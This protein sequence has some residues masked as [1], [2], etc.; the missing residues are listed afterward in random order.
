MFK[1]ILVFG[2]LIII[3]IALMTPS[4]ADPTDVALDQQVEL[5]VPGTFELVDNNQDQKAEAIQFKLTLKAYREGNFI[6]TGNLEGNRNGDWVALAT[7]VIP[8]QWSPDHNQLEL[9]FLAGNILKY[10][11]SGP[12]R[13]VLSLKE[14]DWELPAQVVGFSPKYSLSTF[15]NATTVNSGSITT[16]SQAQRAAE[17]WADFQNISLGE[18]KQVNYN[19]DRWELEYRGRSGEALRFLITPQGKVE[20]MRI[21]NPTANGR[22]FSGSYP[23]K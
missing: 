3:F 11:I 23:A 12:Y 20:L 21:K 17:T 18:L 5:G 1:K 13:V 4:G 15:S 14:G 8:F 9:K 22:S 10:K 16:I 2:T 7:T 19:Y 6:V